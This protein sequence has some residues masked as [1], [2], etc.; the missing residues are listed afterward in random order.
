ML[1]SNKSLIHHLI[2]YQV[3]NLLL[4]RCYKVDYSAIQILKDIDLVLIINNYQL[5]AHIEHKEVF[6][7]DKEMVQCVFIIKIINQTI[8]QIAFNHL[9]LVLVLL[10]HIKLKELSE[11]IQTNIQIQILNKLE[12]SIE[13]L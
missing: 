2:W 9:L 3:L 13:K 11:D 8:T 7:M 4:I 1:K 10:A 6:Q 12:I 5:I